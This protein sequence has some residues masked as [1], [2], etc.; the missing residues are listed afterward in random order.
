MKK[1]NIIQ[2]RNKNLIF[3]VAERGG[4]IMKKV[5]LLV[6]PVILYVF[7][8]ILGKMQLRVHRVYGASVL[9]M[10]LMLAFFFIIIGIFLAI[11]SDTFYEYRKSKEAKIFCVVDLIVPII[12]RSL[13]L[14]NSI[15]IEDVYY[16]EMYFLI[17]G[18]YIYQIV[19]KKKK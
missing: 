18:V 17:L 4:V 2:E 8:F 16:T 11:L 10:S 5:L 7:G 15:M 6:I 14:K 12:V 1:F 13:L 19:R 9:Q 3:F